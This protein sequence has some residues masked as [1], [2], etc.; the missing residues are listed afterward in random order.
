M[1]ANM[2]NGSEHVAGQASQDTLSHKHQ[3]K[4]EH[5]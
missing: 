5:E 3:H 1:G 4:K 2:R